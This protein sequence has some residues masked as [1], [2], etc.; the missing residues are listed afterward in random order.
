MSD[1]PFFGDYGYVPPSLPPTPPNTSNQSSDFTPNIFW[2]ILGVG[3]VIAIVGLII[4]FLTKISNPKELSLLLKT[5]LDQQGNNNAT[6]YNNRTR[7][8]TPDGDTF[9]N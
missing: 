9:Y 8:T 1:I 2:L 7:W 6:F 5:D 4:Y 3:M